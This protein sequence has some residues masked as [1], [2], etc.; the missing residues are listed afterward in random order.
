MAMIFINYYK[1][2]VVFSL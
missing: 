1:Y 2:L